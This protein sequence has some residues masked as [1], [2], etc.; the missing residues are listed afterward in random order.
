[1]VSSGAEADFGAVFSML[2][3]A[4]SHAQPFMKWATNK[5]P[6]SSRLT[7]PPH[8]ASSITQSYKSAQNMRFYWVKD[9]VDQ[10]QINV[11]WA[12]GDTN[13]GDYFMKHHS[14]QALSNDHTCHKIWA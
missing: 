10:D 7:T 6:H 9:R 2:K 11:G 14:W 13:M 4:L 1:V 5:M 8:M 3:K 12:P